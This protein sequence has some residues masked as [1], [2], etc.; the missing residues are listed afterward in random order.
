MKEIKTENLINKINMEE[1]VEELLLEKTF[2]FIIRFIKKKVKTNNTIPTDYSRVFHDYV[3]KKYRKFSLANSLVLK[4]KQIFFND[5]YMPLTLK[6]EEG[7]FEY[8]I[9]NY[10]GSLIDE[11][12]L[13]LI[14]DTAGMG[15]STILKKIFLSS[16]IEKKAIPIF[17]EL[18]RIKEHETLI[19]AISNELKLTNFTVNEKHLEYLFETGGFIFHFDGYD[20]ISNENKSSVTQELQNFV[21]KNIKNNSFILTSR[22]EIS[23]SSFSEFK[24]FKINKLKLEESFELLEK[25]DQSKSIYKTLIEKLKEDEMKPIHEFL[26]N[27]LLTSLLFLAFEYKHKIPLKKHLFYRQVY[28]ANFENHDLS[29]GESFLRQKRCKLHSDDFHRILRFIGFECLK[30]QQIEFEKDQILKIIDNSK[31]FNSDLTFNQNDF[32]NDVILAVPLFTIDGNYY[33]WSHRSIQEYFAAQFIYKDSKAQQINILNTIYDHKALD[34]YLNTLDLYY[35]IDNKTF[36]RII[37]FNILSEFKNHYYETF[38]KYV[39]DIEINDFK[40][41]IELT[42]LKDYFIVQDSNPILADENMYKKELGIIQLDESVIDSEKEQNELDKFPDLKDELFDELYD[43]VTNVAKKNA[44][45][46]GVLSFP[47]PGLNT[48]FASSNSNKISLLKLLHN[49]GKS[50]IEYIQTDFSYYVQIK[51]ND[52][53]QDVVY[54]LDFLTSN[55]FNRENNFKI[56]NSLINIDYQFLING[57]K[58][59]TEFNKLNKEINSNEQSLSNF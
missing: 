39:A 35:D 56:T 57:E 29:K 30:L 54:K 37:E 9:T 28:D 51:I 55:P 14:T 6:S 13:I 25:Y 42:F 45:N 22:P 31:K 2:D 11:F 33:R 50:Y 52:K 23:L 49:K 4:N 1:K 5:I 18:R 8:Q 32:L 43:N 48:F 17:V 16:V 20:E 36:R 53:E 3:E 47:R 46:S 44:T 21:T 40:K 58:A 10:P 59:L 15:K 38:K 24:E 41:R 12:G 7:L 19:N 26:V 27:P 34:Y